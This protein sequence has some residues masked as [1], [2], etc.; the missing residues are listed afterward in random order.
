MVTCPNHAYP[1]RHELKECS[2]MKNY[3]TIGA[4]TKGKNPEGDL[5]GKTATPFTEEKAVM[6][7]Y[8]GSASHDPRRKLKLTSQVVN[9][10]SPATPEYLH[11]S[12]SPVTFNRTYHPDSIP[13]PRRFPLIINPLVGMTRLT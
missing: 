12:D 4:F 3:M 2:M 6:S 11:W 7:N 5:A 8:G 10:I 9:A 13:K 1:I